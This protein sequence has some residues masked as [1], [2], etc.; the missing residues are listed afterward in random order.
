M[1]DILT[2]EHKD[3]GLWLQEEDDHLLYLKF[4]ERRLAAFS[5]TGTSPEEIRKEA[6]RWIERL[7]NEVR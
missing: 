6:T 1:K 3:A 7:K 4:G 5:Q 2:K